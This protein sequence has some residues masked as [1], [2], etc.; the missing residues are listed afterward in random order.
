MSRALAVI[1]AGAWGTALASLLAGKGERVRLWAFEPEVAAG[2]AAAHENKLYLPGVS[3]PA[4]LEPTTSLE[5]AVFGVEAVI[6]VVPSHAAA[7]VAA[8]L[9]PH[10]PAGAPVI[11]AT[12]GIDPAKLRLMSALL[13]EMLPPSR[14]PVF[15]LSG[16]SFA[17]EVCRRLPT[18]V[19]LAGPAGSQAAALQS[20]LMSPTFRVYLSEDRC[21]VELGGALK[22]VIAV[23]AG[24]V[25]GLG[26]GHNTRAA[27]ITRGLAEMVRLGTAMGA[28]PRTFAGLS[29][30]GD[31]VLTCTGALSRNRAVGIQIGQ[32]K[33]LADI[34]AGARTVA[35]G[36][37]T[38]KV[39]LALAERHQVEMPIVREVCAVLFDGKDPRRA[40]MDLMERAARPELDRA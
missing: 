30:M 16:P 23:A 36:V 8:A 32:G 15:A 24:V 22:N 34:L 29:G 12:K 35:E 6:F 25:D 27:L 13:E 4:A 31:L 21:G 2:I 28:D 9:A 33:K 10:L 38:A 19:V 1:G 37:G 7:K 3:L 40:A 20:L 5:E 26:L 11:T 18:A 17:V 39:A 14:G